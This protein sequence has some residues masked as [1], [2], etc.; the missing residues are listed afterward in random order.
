MFE[1]N[2]GALGVDG[3]PCRRKATWTPLMV[4]RLFGMSSIPNYRVKSSLFLFAFELVWIHII[5]P[6][7]SQSRFRSKEVLSVNFYHSNLQKPQILIVGKLVKPIFLMVR[8]ITK[9]FVPPPK[10]HPIFSLPKHLTALWCWNFSNRSP[11]VCLNSPL[12]LNPL[13]SGL[14]AYADT[15]G[16]LC[17]PL[18]SCLGQPAPFIVQGG[19]DWNHAVRVFPIVFHCISLHHRIFSHCPANGGSWWYGGHPGWAR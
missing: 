5:V 2:P 8:S 15:L 10:A 12:Q 18:L 17:S 9:L 4:D 1:G 16:S 7:A 13:E 3:P 6:P 14:S 11:S 19:G